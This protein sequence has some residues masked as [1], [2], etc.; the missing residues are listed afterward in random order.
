M[1]LEPT[2]EDD[3]LIK[4]VT[5]LCDDAKVRDSNKRLERLSIDARQRSAKLVSDWQAWV[6]LE[7]LS[8]AATGSP[9]GDHR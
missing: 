6:G 3:E 7:D 2:R 5:K 8:P 9:Q 4:R 1:P